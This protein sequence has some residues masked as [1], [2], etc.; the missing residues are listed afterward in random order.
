MYC[1]KCGKETSEN[2]VFCDGCLHVMEKYPV[3]PDAAIQ[4]PRRSS[5][6]ASRKAPQRKRSLTAEE[7]V[8]LLKK[9]LRRMTVCAAVLLMVLCLAVALLFRELMVDRDSQPVGRN[10]TIDISGDSAG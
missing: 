8:V 10:Y 2:Q 7:Q 4:L 9:L 6:E 5:A 3:K 1:L